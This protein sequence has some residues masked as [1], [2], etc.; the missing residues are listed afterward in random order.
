MNAWTWV[1]AASILAIVWWAR[2]IPLT[3]SRRRLVMGLRV[4]ALLCVLGALH[5]W[6]HL[7]RTEQP[8]HLVYLMDQSASIDDAQRAW[9][10]RRLASLEAIR[11]RSMTREVMAFGAQARAIFPNQSGPLTD[12]AAVDHALRSA[13]LNRRDTNVEG[14]LVSAVSA[15]PIPARGRI[16]LLSDGR[17]T[18]GD[19]ER[20]L[21]YLRQLGVEVYPV[22]VPGVASS[23][24]GMSWESVTAPPVVQRGS[25]VPLRLLFRNR[26]DHR[27]N[28]T[29]AIR[30]HGV[31]IDQ[32]RVSISPEWRVVTMPVPALKTGTLV[33]DVAVAINGAVQHQPVYVEVEGPPKV[34]VV[35]EKP[36]VLPMVG[37]ALKH[38]DMEVAIATPAELPTDPNELVEYDAVMLAH[39]PKS[40]LSAP[41][42]A[43]LTVY[44]EHFGGGVV[45]VGLGGKWE[46]ELSRTDPLD[47][48][49][50]V[51]F[52][53]K[54]LREAKR[55]VCMVMLIDRSASMM[56]PR[57]AAT[58]RAA[59]ELVKQLEPD[60]LVGVLA[61][62][63]EPYIVAEV[64]PARQVTND[65]IERLV[66]LK[67][68]GGTDILPAL[69]AAQQRLNLTG[70]TVKHIL[71]LSDGVTPFQAKEYAELL[72]TLKQQHITI[73]TI[74]IGA[75]FV[76]TAYLDMLARTT[77][78]SFYQ[79]RNLDELTSLIARDTQQTLAELPFTE[80]HFVPAAPDASEWF[81]TIH[82]WPPLKGYFTTTPKDG[83]H[84][85]LA[86]RQEQE[87]QP[88]LAQWARGAGRVAV[89]ASDAESR[90]SPDW[91]RWPKFEVVWAEIARRVMR[92]RQQENVFAWVERDHG[93]PMLVVEGRLSNPTAELLSTTGGTAP[94]ALG[95]VS[96]YRWRAP[97]EQLDSGWYQVVIHAQAQPPAA[98][99]P[100]PEA[101]PSVLVKRWIQVGRVVQESERQGLP[102]DEAM[103]RHIADATHGVMDV[104]DRAFVPPTDWVEERV[105]LRGWLIPLAMLLVL[106]DVA[107][108]GKTML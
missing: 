18:A 83:A 41:Q 66:H 2:S 72:V 55:R 105:P 54:G 49:L 89:F 103:L 70:A 37:T 44:V 7:R 104:P 99:P 34:L 57:I 40:S 62:D 24:G 47:A 33:L 31:V 98:R 71:L 73:S 88:L 26:A 3:G 35:L 101:A 51:R 25:S 97:M 86:I 16:V 85:E 63:T 91:L 50:P 59:V 29:I 36:T 65:I 61:F 42:A 52:E 48:L 75:A 10:A 30:E 5:G 8:R 74:G 68:T 15:M 43:A 60:D 46:E 96:P 21:G 14:A 90:W 95:Q 9:M 58:K 4:A 108:R 93:A 69:K 87:W 81:D 78:G 38:R 79:M 12:A 92:P 67:S 19:V 28:A 76:N 23:G 106:I 84:L 17:Q 39:V 102:P 6:A 56:G 11:P 13:S 45:M 64:Q 100:A 82:D 20:V 107:L 77:G 1:G 53:P 27:V 32:K 94:L 22:V 80:G